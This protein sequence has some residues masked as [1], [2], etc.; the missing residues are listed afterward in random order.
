LWDCYGNNPNKG[1]YDWIKWGYINTSNGVYDWTLFDA[2][3]AK[4]K[5]K[6]VTDLIYT[7]GVTPT[8]AGGGANNDQAPSSNTYLAN[9]ATAV[10]QRAIADGLPIKN[11]EVW[12]EPNNGALTWTGTNAQMVAMAQ[13]IYNAVKAVDS[14]YKVLTPCPQ[15]NATTWMNGYLAAGGGAYADVMAFHGYTGASPETIATLI[16][17]YKSVFAT[18]GQ[19][20]K[21]IW[22]TEAADLNTSDPTLQ[23]R[24]L[25]IYYLLHQAKG[26]ERFYWY[27]YDAWQGQE[28]YYNTGVSAVGTADIQIHSWMLGATLGALSISGTVYSLPLTKS[29][30][31]TLAVWN[32]AGASAYATG[33]Y[34]HYAD[35]LGVVHSI[36]GGTV[37]IGQDPILLY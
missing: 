34:T 27:A 30:Q 28:W 15:G 7:F 8:W 2:L 10:A 36:S 5:A 20:A 35:L 3:L 17:S 22:D 31:T 21:P 13:T 1:A 29:G 16:D 4:F 14:S 18:Y 19:S 23:A 6:G 12:N 9:F 37:N 33:S 24:F 26:V 32:S 25:A 11:W